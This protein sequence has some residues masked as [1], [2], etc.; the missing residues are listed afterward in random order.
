MG[1]AEKWGAGEV[2]QAQVLQVMT[3]FSLMARGGTGRPGQARC[4]ERL[5][6][7]LFGEPYSKTD[8]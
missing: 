3:G 2:S 8:N 1:A 7:L 4:L 6:L 5:G